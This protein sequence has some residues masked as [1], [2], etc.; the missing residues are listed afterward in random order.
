[1]NLNNGHSHLFYGLKVSVIKCI[2]NPKVH[3]KPLRYAASIDIALS[4]KLN[5]D[6]GYAGF[7]CKN[8]LHK[9]WNVQVWQRELYDLSWIAD[10]LD[11]EPYKDGRKHLPPVG[12]G[13]NCTMFEL[14]RRWAYTQIRKVGVYSNE[15]SFIESVTNYAAGKNEAFPV[16]LPYPEVKATGKSVGRW[17]WRNMSPE[18][19]I[20][21]CS[22][23]GKAGNIKSV[24]VRQTKSAERADEIRAYKLVHPEMSNVKIAL[25]FGVDEKTVR[26]ALQG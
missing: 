5:A 6:P 7:I 3:Q 14:T 11:L 19:F 12:L 9:H 24:A 10:Y 4:L 26:R 15:A 23:R 21:W 16:P 2:E 13:R 1:M 20:E 18:G 17:T 8:P 22:R 25:V